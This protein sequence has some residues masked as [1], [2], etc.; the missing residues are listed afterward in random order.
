MNYFASVQNKRPI[1]RIH[2]L[3]LS[4]S[5]AFSKSHT[6]LNISSISE[7]DPR[8]LGSMHYTSSSEFP[9]M[10]IHLSGDNGMHLFSDRSITFTSALVRQL[11]IVKN[12][13]GAS[14]V[15]FLYL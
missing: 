6:S 11:V 3:L 9:P 12:V 1:P 10:D 15:S 14:R 2:P 5:E 8:V 7:D 13:R 4:L